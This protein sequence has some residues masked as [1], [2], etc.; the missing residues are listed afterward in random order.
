LS[1]VLLLVEAIV[2]VDI[3]VWC[4]LVRDALDATKSVVVRVGRKTG[5]GRNPG[6]GK[7][8]IGGHSIGWRYGLVLLLHGVHVVVE[9]GWSARREV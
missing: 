1:D 4:C 5:R 7:S 2:F 3:M 6:W 8:R 9:L